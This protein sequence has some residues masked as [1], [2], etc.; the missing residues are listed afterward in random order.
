MKLV[1]TSFSI[2]PSTDGGPPSVG[3]A[4][5]VVFP[6][7]DFGIQHA[8]GTFGVTFEHPSPEELTFPQVEQLARERILAML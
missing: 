4:L 6:N 1:L 8:S 5:D 2:Y 7:T 3:A